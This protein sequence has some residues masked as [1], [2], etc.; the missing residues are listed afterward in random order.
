[1]E[2]E[3][4]ETRRL[5]GRRGALLNGERSCIAGATTTAGRGEH[6]NPA[7]SG[8]IERTQSAVNPRLC[9]LRDVQDS[10]AV[11]WSGV[12]KLAVHFSTVALNE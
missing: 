12:Y 1:M 8:V 10:P 6:A 5:G 4:S 7:L 11:P 9:P 3:G 2:E